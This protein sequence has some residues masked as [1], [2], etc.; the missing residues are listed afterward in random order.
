LLPWCGN[1]AVNAELPNPVD[2]R[3]ILPVLT[4]LLRIGIAVTYLVVLILCS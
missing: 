3:F 1:F 2:F 4:D